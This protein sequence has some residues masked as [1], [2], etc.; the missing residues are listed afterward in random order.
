MKTMRKPGKHPAAGQVRRREQ[1]RLAKRAQRERDR[2]A[3]LV[4]CQLKLHPAVAEKLRGGVA[5]P[6][7]EDALARFLDESLVD[8]A[9]YPNLRLLCWNRAERFV[10]A[11]EAFALYERNWRF[12][13]E[14]ALDATERELIGRLA[15]TYGGGL[16]NV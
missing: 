15:R 9:A 1:L 10:P 7:F 12:V 16:L 4:L 8:V 13:D 5:I 3:G 11:A 2:E 6:G 14:K